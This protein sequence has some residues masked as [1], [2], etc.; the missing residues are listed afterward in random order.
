MLIK[1]KILD[2]VNKFL[3]TIITTPHQNSTL[4]T[5]TAEFYQVLKE[6]L[7]PLLQNHLQNKKKGYPTHFMRIPILWYQNPMKNVYKRNITYS[8]V[9]NLIERCR[10]YIK[11]IIKLNLAIYKNIVS[12]P[13]CSGGSTLEANVILHF[14]HMKREK[15]S[16][17]ESNTD[18]RWSF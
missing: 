1:V 18:A 13:Q 5:H 12:W 10:N 8:R 9:S 17:D 15:L 7:I 16:L 11:N 3:K 6:E 14:Q 2:E 4:G